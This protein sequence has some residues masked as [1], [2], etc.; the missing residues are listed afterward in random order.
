[1]VDRKQALD[2]MVKEP[3]HKKDDHVEVHGRVTSVKHKESFVRNRHV[4]Y[5]FGIVVKAPDNN[6][7]WFRRGEETQHRHPINEG[8]VVTVSGLVSGIADDGAMFF[9][10]KTEIK[11]DVQ[12]GHAILEKKAA[13]YTCVACSELVVASA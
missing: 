13:G 5:Y 7:Y 12:C 2:R 3:K 9:L 8:D 11:G 10:H 6:A 1:M 4:G